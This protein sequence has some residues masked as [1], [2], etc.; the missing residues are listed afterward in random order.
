MQAQT[1]RLLCGQVCEGDGRSGELCVQGTA[2]K[3]VEPAERTWIVGCGFELCTAAHR[4]R[5]LAQAVCVI[6]LRDRFSSR[7]HERVL[8]SLRA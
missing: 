5:P 4:V 1:G 8:L 3:R 7:V 2:D 6:V